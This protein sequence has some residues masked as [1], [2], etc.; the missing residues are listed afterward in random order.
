MIGPTRRCAAAAAS[1]VVLASGV[2]AAADRPQDR[3]PVPVGASL[4]PTGTSIVDVTPQIPVRLCGYAARDTEPTGVAQRLFA[5]ALAVGASDR[6]AV[7]VSVDN[8]AVPASIVEEVAR[9][10]REKRGVARERLTVCSTHT[11]TGPWLEGSI[12]CMFGRPVPADQLERVHRYTS[13][14]VD[15]IEEAALAAIDARAPARLAWAEGRAHFAKN[16]RTAGGPT[17]PALPV[18]AAW[19]EDGSLLAVLQNYA[20]HC[21]TCGPAINQYCGDWAGY[22]SEYVEAAHAGAVAL[23]VIG[24]G[25]DA[26]PSPGVT[27]RL[28]DSMDHGRAIASEVERLLAG[29]MKPLLTEGKGAAAPI[30]RLVRLELPFDT[31][32]TREQLVERARRGNA[33]DALGYHASWWLSKLDRGETMPA[34]LPCF[35]QSWVWGDELAQVFLSGEVV[36]DYSLRLKREF[37]RSRLWVS[38]YTNDVACYIPSRRILAEG[39]YEAEGAMTY[40]GRPTRL[41]ASCEEAII[42]AVHAQ[43]PASFA[44]DEQ[45]TRFPPPKSPSESLACIRV[46]Q[47][48][49]R[50][51][52]LGE[53]QHGKWLTPAFDVELVASEPVI[54][55]PVALDFGADGTVWI[56]EMNDY[57]SGMDGKYQPGGR[58]KWLRD[59]DGDGSYES[60]GLFTEGLPFPTGVMAW[61][62]GVLICAAPDILYAEDRD[63][64]GRAD[65]KRVLFTGFSTENYQARVNSLTWG[66]DGW[67][68]GA[69]GLFGGVINGVDCRGRDFRIDPDRLVIE[70][71]EGTS[72]QGRVRDD[73]GR[74]FGCDSGCLVFQFPLADRYVKRNPF[75]AAPDPR[76][77][78]L[79]DSRDEDS[80]QLFQISPKLER[81]NDQS[82]LSRVT[83]ACGIGIYRDVLL[84]EQVYGNA[85]TCEPVANVVRRVVFLRQHFTNEPPDVVLHGHRALEDDKDQREFLASSDPWFR[86]VQAATGPDGALWIADMYRFVIEHPRWIPA[87]KLAEMDVRAGATLGRIYRVLPKGGKPRPVKDL[88]KLSTSELRAAFETTNGVVRDLVHRE[89]LQR[90]DSKEDAEESDPRDASDAPP[91]AAAA[92]EVQ[93]AWLHQQQGSIT[94]RELLRLLDAEL[95]SELRAQAMVLCERC[96]SE[97]PRLAEFVGGAA[98]SSLPKEAEPIVGRRFGPD[99]LLVFQAALS[100]GEWDSPRAGELL[101][102]ILANHLDHPWIRAAV[103]SSATKHADA[104]L[105]TLLMEPR[106]SPAFRDTLSR[107]VATIVGVGDPAAYARALEAVVPKQDAEAD[108]TWRW[109]ALGELELAVHRRGGTNSGIV[110]VRRLASAAK[111]IGLASAAASR[112]LDSA[113]DAMNADSELDVERV[114]AA[115]TLLPQRADADDHATPGQL[116]SIVRFVDSRAP[117]AIQ[118][119]AVQALTRIADPSVPSLL[120][121]MLGSGTPVVR[122]LVLDALMQRPA[123]LAVLLE[124]AETGKA[125]KQAFDAAHRDRLLKHDDPAIR[126]RAEKL[127]APAGTPSRASVLEAFRPA[128]DLKG[129]VARGRAHFTKLCASCHSVRGIGHE[130]APDL[131]ALGDRSPPRLLEAIL[132]PNAAVNADYV[133]YNVDLKDG[134]SLNGL[135]RAETS[136][137]F[138]LVQANDVRRTLLRSE[139]AQVKPSKLSLMPE[140]LDE[141]LAPQDLA[142][143]IAFL[144]SAPV[145]LD[146]ITTEQAAAAR[147]ELGKLDLNGYARLVGAFDVFSQPTWLGACTMHYCRQ[148]DGSAKVTWRTAPVSGSTFR[149]AAA[150]GF[151]SQPDGDF[152][153]SLDGKPL[154]VFDVA[155]DDA[156]WQSKDGRATLDFECRAA[157]REDATG[158]MTLTLPAELV[159]SGKPVELEVVGSAANSQRWFGVLA[160]D[161]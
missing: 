139:V 74:W 158:V 112:A 127:F 150:L 116:E 130:L 36:V 45:A 77:N 108:E 126:A 91:V 154:L 82:D 78:L 12:D 100:L 95:P 2:A 138:T 157:N 120:L 118:Q 110:D 90:R 64:D 123:W 49:E 31:L 27:S 121:P 26:N 5:R 105:A 97:S 144:R 23:T 25:A 89:L 39:G 18:I 155:I 83:S 48:S 58:V 67:V 42:A 134:D 13:W 22:A 80:R 76:W 106:D 85:F 88:T 160:P 136:T 147:A 75:I 102:G 34:T 30:C 149:F 50:D 55:S 117:A 119:A 28:Q 62:K 107:L 46:N 133:A 101:G 66:L 51:F 61:R 6:V 44:S 161:E 3:A 40:Y 59:R 141:G 152:T 43:L 21:T 125:P 8:A 60:S 9:R 128:L 124:A 37:D 19:G 156:H 104:I 11:H 7:I 53:G 70:P 33:S 10:L 38:G 114:L 87:A 29:E 159:H 142:D 145:P 113:A 72:Q 15:R 24:C 135:I 54:E 17:D 122:A 84:G 69:C 86:P 20:C 63:G 41:A 93:R 137:G 47:E 14:L 99:S 109:I 56:C 148:S 111:L 94:E 1:L 151:L 103:L 4:V 115:L 73:F 143:L 131:M 71:I 129:D 146:S 65:V 32:P 52:G 79:A 132:D 92:I 96:F 153:L 140:G 57:P 98:R 81:F 35:V 68:Y 16:R